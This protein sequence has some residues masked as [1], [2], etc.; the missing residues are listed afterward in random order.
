MYVSMQASSTPVEGAGSAATGD[1]SA[2]LV[3]AGELLA[4]DCFIHTLGR[5]AD[6]TPIRQA[7]GKRRPG[8]NKGAGGGS[9]EE[10]EGEGEGAGK[11]KTVTTSQAAVLEEQGRKL[12]YYQLA[13]HKVEEHA[14]AIGKTSDK[15]RWVCAIL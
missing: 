13:K 10:G 5:A 1:I 12:R 11:G 14:E 4:P 6:A 15:E 9:K 3:E 7:V 2:V 8:G